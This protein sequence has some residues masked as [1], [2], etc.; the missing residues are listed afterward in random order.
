MG[1]KRKFGHGNENKLIGEIDAK[2]FREYQARVIKS[3][4]E[5]L[6]NGMSAEQIFKKYEAHAAA[7]LIS[8]MTD[9]KNAV[10]A[11][12]KVLDRTQGK[13]VQKQETTHRLEKLKDSELDSFLNSR[14]S[15]LQGDDTDDNVQ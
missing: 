11:A 14:L 1:R 3:V 10:Q 4:R 15:E 2:A 13:A 6:M 9:P 12:E 5:D 7:A 8:Q